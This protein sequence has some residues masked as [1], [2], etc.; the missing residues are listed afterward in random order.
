MTAAN[1]NRQSNGNLSDSSMWLCKVDVE[2]QKRER[3]LPSLT[4]SC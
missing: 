4:A 3:R 1:S 2:L